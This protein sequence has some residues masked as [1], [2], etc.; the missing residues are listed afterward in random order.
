[1]GTVCRHTR[2]SLTQAPAAAVT[3]PPPSPL[4]PP[5]PAERVILHRHHFHPE[6]HVLCTPT[7]PTCLLT[8]NCATSALRHSPC[9]CQR[10]TVPLPPRAFRPFLLP[11]SH[12]HFAAQ[13]PTSQHSIPSRTSPVPARRS[14]TALS[15]S[16]HNSKSL[17]YPKT[18]TNIP[19]RSPA[20]PSQVFCPATPAMA[21]AITAI[22]PSFSKQT[23]V[24]VCLVSLPACHEAPPYSRH[25]A[26]DQAEPSSLRKTV[27]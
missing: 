17:L 15:C 5:S 13:P 12:T 9:R 23:W 3:A 4:P 6:Q 10:P 25:R 1:M 8:C 27:G 16:A 2:L 11:Q 22:T 18:S 21:T 14:V 7:S 24:W 26:C 19:P 20:F